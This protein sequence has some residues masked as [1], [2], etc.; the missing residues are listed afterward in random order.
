MSEIVNNDKLS[1][2]HNQLMELNTTILP[3]IKTDKVA[4]EWF[5]AAETAQLPKAVAAETTAT[6]AKEKEKEKEKLA[7]AAT[8]PIAPATAA[9]APIAPIATLAAESAESATLAAVKPEVKPEVKPAVSASEATAAVSASEATA[10]AASEATAAAASEATAAASEATLASTEVKSESA[11][12]APVPEDD[13]IIIRTTTINKDLKKI[14]TIQMIHNDGTS[15]TYNTTCDNE[16]ES[17]TVTKLFEPNIENIPTKYNNKQIITGNNIPPNMEF[18]SN[19]TDPYFYTY[20]VLSDDGNGCYRAFII[21][22]IINYFIFNSKVEFTNYI[23][24][25]INTVTNDF[26]KLWEK[27]E[28]TIMCTVAQK[29]IIDTLNI[30]ILL[31]KTN[32]IE[33]YNKLIDLLNTSYVFD[34]YMIVYMRLKLYDI[35]LTK[36]EDKQYL[37]IYS[38]KMDTE[39]KIKSNLFGNPPTYNSINK[40]YDIFDW[41]STM[42][43]SSFYIDN[44]TNT[45][46]NNTIQYKIIIYSSLTLYRYIRLNHTNLYTLDYIN[47]TI[48]TAKAKYT[49]KAK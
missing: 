46:T 15:H 8:A 48:N 44:N 31:R 22:N 14:C 49:A 33:E 36:P 1:F 11:V 35:L 28:S 24:I 9:T 3:G 38:N 12:T 19:I 47:T 34:Y 45:N 18:R 21:S 42:K 5:A 2:T 4:K 41:E 29:I 26:C 17:Q 37:T 23:N 25:I 27:H 20:S 43:L 7:T 32:I 30:I 6:A 10:A 16:T 13:D 40:L 39:L